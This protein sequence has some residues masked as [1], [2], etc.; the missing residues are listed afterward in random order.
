MVM[1]AYILTDIVKEENTL[2]C[3]MFMLSYDFM[4]GSITLCQV[5]NGAFVVSASISAK[6][7]EQSNMLYAYEYCK[8]AVDSFATI[9]SNH[10]VFDINWLKQVSNLSE[11]K[12]P[13]QINSSSFESFYHI[14]QCYLASINQPFIY[15]PTHIGTN[16]YNMHLPYTSLN[17]SYYIPMI[18]APIYL[19]STSFVNKLFIFYEFMHKNLSY[20]VINTYP[21]INL[22]IIRTKFVKRRLVYNNPMAYFKLTAQMIAACYL[23]I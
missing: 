3:S 4:Q 16:H 9:H 18:L 7:L 11:F 23:K 14:K 1:Q 6:L 21:K 19:F 5:Y 20:L 12:S 13:K 22:S 2:Y 17:F 8:V 15:N 10:S